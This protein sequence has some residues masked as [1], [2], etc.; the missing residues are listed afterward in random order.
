MGLSE[1]RDVV[2]CI[3]G[4]CFGWTRNLTDR[5]QDLSKKLWLFSPEKYLNHFENLGL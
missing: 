2:S 1:R 4:R 3:G 5:A